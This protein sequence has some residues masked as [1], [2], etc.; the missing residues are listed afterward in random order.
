MAGLSDFIG[1]SNK[2]VD[3]V[4]LSFD[5]S[6][7]SDRLTINRE[8]VEAR[9]WVISRLPDRGVVA[10]Q[11]VE[12]PVIADNLVG[13]ILYLYDSDGKPLPD[14]DTERDTTTG[15]RTISVDAGSD[16]VSMLEGYVDEGSLVDITDK[17]KSSVMV[18]QAMS[19]TN[20]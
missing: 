10:L 19:K 7:L 5:N 9:N 15:E 13:A 2:G 6:F 11:I 1:E 8:Y 18:V 14:E 4:K 17:K 3:A 16:V 20:S 12:Y